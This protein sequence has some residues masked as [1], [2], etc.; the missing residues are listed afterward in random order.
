M[1]DNRDNSTDSRVR[2]ENGGV[3]YVPFENIVGRAEIIFFS[4]NRGANQ[5]TCVSTASVPSYDRSTPSCPEV[6]GI[7]S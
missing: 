4:I 2:P 3:G 7:Q 6:E 1:G 5:P